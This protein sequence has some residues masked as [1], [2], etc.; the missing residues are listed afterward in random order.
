MQRMTDLLAERTRYIDVFFAK[1]QQAGADIRQIVILASG[2]DARGYRLPWVPGTTVF[3]IDQ[4]E[5][6]EFKTAAVYAA[7]PIVGRQRIT[8]ATRW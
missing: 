6:S 5:V 7:E 2:L 8:T 4:P 1:A 3:E